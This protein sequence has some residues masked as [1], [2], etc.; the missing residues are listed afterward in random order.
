MRERAFFAFALHSSIP[1][2][3]SFYSTRLSTVLLPTLCLSLSLPYFF[4]GV[5]G[6]SIVVTRCNVY[7]PKRRLL[8]V[9]TISVYISPFVRVS[10]L[11]TVLLHQLDFYMPST[12]SGSTPTS[13]VLTFV[14]CLRLS[15]DLATIN[16]ICVH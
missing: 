5:C 13:L 8:F 2:R 7:S 10:I 12:V 14:F 9:Y 3:I 11:F 1:H 4:L 16:L 15:Y 6:L